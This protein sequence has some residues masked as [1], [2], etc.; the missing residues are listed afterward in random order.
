MNCGPYCRQYGSAIVC[1]KGVY[2][3]SCKSNHAAQTDGME[4]IICE[5]YEK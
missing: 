2:C 5:V 3:I 4:D 1:M